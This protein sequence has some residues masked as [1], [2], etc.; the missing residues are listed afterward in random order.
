MWLRHWGLTHD[1]FGAS[2]A[3]YVPMATH[4]EALARVIFAVDRGQR[5]ISLVADAGLGKTMVAREAVRQLRNPRRRAIVVP[6]PADGRQLLG[7]VAD[8]LGLPFAAGSDREGIWRSLVRV[9]GAAA[10]EGRHVVVFID[11]W[12]EEPDAAIMKDLTALTNQAVRGGPPLSVVRVGRRAGAEDGSD[13]WTLAI[14]LERLT[15][16]EAEAYLQARLKAAGCRDPLFTPRAVVRLHSWSDGVPR[17]LDELAS[18]ALVA[19]A[20][21]GQEVVTPDVVDGVA[22]SNLAGGDR[23][24][25][26]R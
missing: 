5:A 15:H 8:G 7:R 4:D 6:A 14:G 1:P 3:P 19:G 16:M 18:V 23:V 12:D 20:I 10:V 21:Q 13:P 25:V 26:E 9:L 17:A 22:M 11:G 2:P 24:A